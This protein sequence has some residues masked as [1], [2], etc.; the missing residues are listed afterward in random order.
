MEFNHT[1]VLYVMTNELDIALRY[2]YRNVFYRGVRKR[3]SAHERE[4]SGIILCKLLDLS[5]RW[6]LLGKI[7]IF[8]RW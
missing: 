5:P 6:K 8:V 4:R 1:Q 7:D 2:F 3:P